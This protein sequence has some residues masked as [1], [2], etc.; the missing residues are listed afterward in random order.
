VFHDKKS[1]LDRSRDQDTELDCHQAGRTA[2]SGSLTV[3]EAKTYL[4]SFL[5]V[6]PVAGIC[7]SIW[8]SK[9]SRL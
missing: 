4:L 6:L 1:V 8:N 7:F 5:G 2:V 3:S 9:F